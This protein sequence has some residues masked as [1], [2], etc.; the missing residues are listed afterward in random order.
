MEENIRQTMKICIKK[1]I[2]ITNGSIKE[3]TP[4]AKLKILL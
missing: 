1:L 4:R 3:A 2:F